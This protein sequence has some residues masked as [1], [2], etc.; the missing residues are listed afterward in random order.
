MRYNKQEMAYLIG[1]DIGTTNTKALLYDPQ[2]GR[3]VD[4]AARPT[5]TDHPIPD[6]SQHDPEQLWQTVTDCLRQVAAGRPVAGLAVSS[7]AEAGVGLD[8]HGQPVYPIIAWYD[9]RTDPQAAWWETQL[10]AEELH[11]ITGQRVSIS[12]GVN[13]WLW[14]H[15]NHPERARRMKYWLSVPDYILWRLSGERATDYTIASRTMLFDQRRLDWSDELLQRA[16]LYREQLPQPLPSGTCMGRV[17]AEAAAQTGLPVGTPCVLGG[18]D[19]LCTTF[20]AGAYRPGTAV[21]SSGTA[22]GL[23]LFLNEFQTGPLFARQAYSCYAHVAP[24]RFVLK[25]GSKAAGGAIQWLVRQLAGPG[26]E[27]GQLP[28]DRLEIEAQEG[29]G[30]RVGPL[31]LPHFI[32]SGPP[33][34]D[35][36]GR[37]ALVGVQIE[38]NRGDLFRALLEG[39]AF[40]THHGLRQMQALTGQEL[41]QA[42]LTGGTT[43]SRLLVQLKADVLNLP[44]SVPD[45]P[46]ASASGAALLAGLGCGLFASPIEAVDSLHYD[47]TVI[48]PEPKRVAWYAALY[49]RVYAPLYQALYDTNHAMAELSGERGAFP[50]A[51]GPAG[52]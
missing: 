18:H 16:G 34:S 33:D 25:G 42:I 39:L 35:R 24:G 29:V 28:Y 10:S 27:E 45:V 11:A 32:G 51:G 26:A 44:V 47:S 38:H 37:A 48:E 13:K 5:P 15:Q 41:E 31:W 40:N 14:I 4:Q 8:E 49:Q 30:K 50:P 7:L 46:E 36:Y 1:I 2:Q 22:Q 19:H 3:V 17:T 21:D 9:R 20:A 43:R 52:G 12:F 23:M 6:W